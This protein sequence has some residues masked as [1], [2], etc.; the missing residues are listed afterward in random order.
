[1]LFRSVNN[2]ER[3]GDAVENL[4]E[5]IQELIEQDLH[6]SEGGLYDYQVISDEARRFIRLILEA[7]KKDDKT[8]M[9]RAQVLEDSI[10]NMREEM[11]GNY[12]MRLQSGICT[13]DPGLILVDMLTAFEKIGDYCYNIAQAVAGVK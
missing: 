3:M 7:M 13:V 10:N 8:V 2:F 12:L 6:L 1:M 4:A 5:L 9:G 11:R